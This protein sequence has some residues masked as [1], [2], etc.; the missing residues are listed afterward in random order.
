MFHHTRWNQFFWHPAYNLD[1]SPT[2][3]FAGFLSLQQR[4]KHLT[5]FLL[6][7][8]SRGPRWSDIRDIPRGKWLPGVSSRTSPIARPF[9]GMLNRRIL[10]NWAHEVKF[11]GSLQYLQTIYTHQV[12]HHSYP[13]FFYMGS[14]FCQQ[15][16]AEQNAPTKTSP[17]EAEPK[18]SCWGHAGAVPQETDVILDS[19]DP[20]KAIQGL[21]VVLGVGR[22]EFL[23]PEKLRKTMKKLP[24][25]FYCSTFPFFVTPEPRGMETRTSTPSRRMTRF[26]SP[27]SC[28]LP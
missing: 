27:I 12:G 1:G 8:P 16:Y 2:D 23:I 17:A 11:F 14:W 4:P 21:G 13:T 28:Q 25:V 7:Y 24:L 5:V 3:V 22:F 26:N 9:F 6:K 10:R 18:K 15:K 19:L 20:D